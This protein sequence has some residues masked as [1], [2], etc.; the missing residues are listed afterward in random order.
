MIKEKSPRYNVR[1]KDDK[2][3]PYLKVT[4]ERF[5]R[6]TVVR[7][8]EKGGRTFGPYT[9]SA[10]VRTTMRFLRKLFPIRTCNL[11]LSGELNYR[12]CLLYH[13]GR[14]GAPWACRRKKNITS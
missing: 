1:L 8:R 2:H 5:P 12:P 4:D 7:R 3:Y 13:I 6:V 9:D 10:A 11:D 14:C